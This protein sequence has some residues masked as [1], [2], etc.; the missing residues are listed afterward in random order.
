[1]DHNKLWKI[2]KEM[3]IP[4]HLTCFLR[5]LYAS[6]EA[7]V[8]TGHR[9]MDW[10]QMGKGVCQSCMVSPCLLIYIQSESENHSVMSNSLSPHGLYSPW[11]F[12]GQNTGVGSLFL[13]QVI[14]PTQGLNPGLP[15]Y[16]QTLY[17]LSHQGRL[18]MKLV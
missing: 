7:T 14:F 18:H 10:F 2:L 5:N 4:D 17:P 1:M 15:H 9:T 13:L 8:R 3:G 12:P 11:N 6:Q 16:R